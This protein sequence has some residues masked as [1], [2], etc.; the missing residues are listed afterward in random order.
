MG[1]V[2]ARDAMRVRAVVGRI[3]VL[4]AAGAMLVPSTAIAQWGRERMGG[5]AYGGGAYG[6]SPEA[7]YGYQ[8]GQPPAYGG[9]PPAGYAAPAPGPYAAP[10]YGGYAASGYPPAAYPPPAYQQSYA[11]P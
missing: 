2:K 7:R 5:G 11:Y 9:Y 10:G 1:R 6:G 4:L 8:G 3:A